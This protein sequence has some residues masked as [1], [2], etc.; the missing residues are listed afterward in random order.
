MLA[1][2]SGLVFVHTSASRA[3]FVELIE[4]LCVGC[5]LFSFAEIFN[6]LAKSIHLLLCGVRKVRLYLDR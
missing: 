6:D 4:D 1:Y 5:D 3:F 2:L